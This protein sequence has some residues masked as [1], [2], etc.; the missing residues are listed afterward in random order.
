MRKMQTKPSEPRLAYSV[1][2]V[3]ALLGAG[4]RTVYRWVGDGTIRSVKIGGLI[5]IP[6]SALDELLGESA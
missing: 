1:E 4:H 5:R 2:E 3:A 6:V